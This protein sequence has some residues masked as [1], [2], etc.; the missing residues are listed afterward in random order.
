MLVL[1]RKVGDSILINDNIEVT[2]TRIGHGR[3]AL[4]INA[5]QEVRMRRRELVDLTDLENDH[6]ATPTARGFN[7]LVTSR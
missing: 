2:V 6:P 3:V 5:P 4:G 7:A 1:S